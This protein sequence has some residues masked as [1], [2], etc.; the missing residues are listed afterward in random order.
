MRPTSGSTLKLLRKALNMKRVTIYDREGQAAWIAF[1][2]GLE[3]G[4]RE[5]AELLEA[6]EK[7]IPTAE[8]WAC[9]CEINGE[10]TKTRAHLNV[11][12]ARAAIA[13]AREAVTA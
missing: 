5:L 9:T 12:Q 2:A 11:Q 8:N 13:K 10:G 4:R 1:R 7:L 3:Q 6:V